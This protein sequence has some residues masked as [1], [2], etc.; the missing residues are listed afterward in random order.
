VL[1]TA[2]NNNITL[3]INDIQITKHCGGEVHSCQ[4]D[5]EYNVRLNCNEMNLKNPLMKTS[6][7]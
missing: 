4:Y 6:M 1:T 3:F 7:H 5:E 2:T